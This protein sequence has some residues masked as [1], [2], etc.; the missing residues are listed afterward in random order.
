M[1]N[2]DCLIE[3]SLDANPKERER[4]EEVLAYLAKLLSSCKWRNSRV[5]TFYYQRVWNYEIED[6]VLKMSRLLRCF[7]FACGA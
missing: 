7:R 5:T 3:T 2:V 1:M 4:V 6:F